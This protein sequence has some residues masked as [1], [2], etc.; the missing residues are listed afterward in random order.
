M[1]YQII[2]TSCKSIDNTIV[3]AGR[4]YIAYFDLKAETVIALENRQ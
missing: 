3:A 2:L 1:I 4:Y